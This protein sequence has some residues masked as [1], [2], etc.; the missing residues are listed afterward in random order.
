[1]D[2]LP[3]VV[4]LGLAALGVLGIRDPDNWGK[5][6]QRLVDEM[7]RYYRDSNAWDGSQEELSNRFSTIWIVAGAILILSWVV[8]LLW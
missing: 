6:Y 1:M 5:W 2:V 7:P 3:L 8:I 4:G